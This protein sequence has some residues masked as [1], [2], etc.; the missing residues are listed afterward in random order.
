LPSGLERAT[1][2]VHWLPTFVETAISKPA[3]MLAGDVVDTTQARM[4]VLW[5]CIVIMFLSP[6]IVA[7]ITVAAS[8]DTETIVTANDFAATKATNITATAI[9]FFI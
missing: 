5:F 7:S 2:R 9:I 1:L 8:V 6:G 3:L 4:S